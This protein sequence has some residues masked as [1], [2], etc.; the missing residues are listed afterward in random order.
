[1]PA[2][3]ADLRLQDFAKQMESSKAGRPYLGKV[4][5]ICVLLR[6]WGQLTGG[7]QA[8]LDT[9]PE[10]AGLSFEVWGEEC[11]AI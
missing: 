11:P 3:I 5:C 9:E 8:A 6:S 7:Q 4:L 2:G 10:A 1:M